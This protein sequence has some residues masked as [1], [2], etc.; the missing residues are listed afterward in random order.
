VPSP[1]E[2]A[3][4]ALVAEARA[5]RDR[6]YAPV[7]RF[8][9][10]AALRLRDGSVVRGCNVEHVVLPETVCAEKVALVKAVSDGHTDFEAVAVITQ[11]SPAAT[12]CGSCRQ[13]LH[14]WRVPRVVVANTAGDVAVWS[15]EELLPG[16][17]DLELP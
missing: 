8:R 12:P 10:G 2:A 13:M 1:P 17:F 5:A 4:L 11:S 14:A 6:A 3:D 15:L 16:A 7:S 9:V